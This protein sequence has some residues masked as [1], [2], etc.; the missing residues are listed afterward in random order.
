MKNKIFISLFLSTVLCADTNLNNGSILITSKEIKSFNTQM[1]VDLLNKLPGVKASDSFISLQGSTT[2]EVLV[3]FDGRPLT[4]S[5]TGTASLGGISTENLEKIEI[6]KG[7]GAALYG[8]NTSGGV[9]VITSKKTNKSYVNKINI[10]KGSLDTEKVG[11]NIGKT[12]DGFGLAF[13][14]NHDKSDG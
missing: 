12:F 11:L 13:D 9:I 5:L 14:V 3:L 8:D 4:D 2:N 10:A 7:S 1:L 6:I